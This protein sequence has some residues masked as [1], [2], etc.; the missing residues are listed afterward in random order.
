M[1]GEYIRPSELLKRQRETGQSYW[2]LIG[3][4]LYDEGKDSESIIEDDPQKKADLM[5]AIDYAL[6]LSLDKPEYNEGKDKVTY[7]AQDSGLSYGSY[8]DFPTGDV[9]L[10][11]QKLPEF[12]D[13]KDSKKSRFQEAVSGPNKKEVD[14]TIDQLIGYGMSPIHVAGIVGNFAQESLFDPNAKGVGGFTGI[15]QMSPDMVKEVKRAYGKVNTKTINS[16]IYDSMSQNE[17]ISKEWRA[18]MKQN[19]GYYNNTYKTPGDAAVAFGKVFERPNEKYANWDQRSLS[20]QHAHDYIMKRYPKFQKKGKVVKKFN[21]GDDVIYDNPNVPINIQY[22]PKDSIV[23]NPETGGV[24]TDNGVEGGIMLPEVS[25]VSNK[26]TAAQRLGSYMKK[27]PAA[28]I[29]KVMLGT[30]ALGTLPITAQGLSSLAPGSAFWTN[31]ITQETFKSTIGALGVDAITKEISGITPEEYVENLGVP[32]LIS[33][34]FNPGGYATPGA[35]KTI[36]NI[37]DVVKNNVSNKVF[38]TAYNHNLIKDPLGEPNVPKDYFTLQSK[39]QPVL[40]KYGPPDYSYVSTN[41]ELPQYGSFNSSQQNLQSRI[42]PL[43]DEDGNVNMR[44]LAQEVQKFYKSHPEARNYKTVYNDSG[45]LYQHIRDVVKTAQDS[46]IP[47]GYTRQQYIQ[48]ALFHDIGK[49]LNGSRKYHGL[50]SVDM[51]KEAGIDIDSSVKHAI[52]SHM[53][54]NMLDQDPLT[55]A[56]RF[57]DVGRG[58][59][60]DKTAYDFPYLAYPGM[61][62]RLDEPPLI[63]L[64]EELKTRINPWLMSKGYKTI[65]LNSSMEEAEKLVNQALDQHLS[66]LR[67]VRLPKNPRNYSD[68]VNAAK[69]EFNTDTPSDKQI[70]S[71]TATHVPDEQSGSGRVGLFESPNN[72]VYLGADP[73]TKDGLYLS[74]SN[75]VARTYATSH[76]N[77]AGAQVVIKLRRD[78]M[79]PGESLSEYILRSD[80]SMYDNNTLRLGDRQLYDDPYR[81]QTGRSL[82]QDMIKEDPNFPRGTLSRTRHTTH[83]TEPVDEKMRF[84]DGRFVRVARDGENTYGTLLNQVNKSLD[85]LGISKKIE[86]NEDGIIFNPEGLERLDFILKDLCDLKNGKT[87][88][89]PPYF[90][91]IFSKKQIKN[92]IRNPH[93]KDKDKY[94]HL[95][96][97]AQKSLSEYFSGIKKR[98]LTEEAK[99]II[100]EQTKYLQDPQ[101]KVRFMRSK[102]IKPKYEIEGF[103]DVRLFG[104]QTPRYDK[105]KNFHQS[106]FVGFVIGNKG[107]KVADV[108]SM[109]DVNPL[110]RKYRDSATEAKDGLSRKSMGQ[111]LLKKPK[112]RK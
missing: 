88:N 44:K 21:N 4:P 75:S 6:S 1:K 89:I 100:A 83:I 58:R 81:L 110:K 45:N 54:D 31:P 104:Q 70:L 98:H 25:V 47:K 69:K 91:N 82:Q 8:Y 112:K 94:L 76:D 24:V 3:R 80:P 79:R 7:V 2:D 86:P 65:P 64:R 14:A 43:V 37:A 96:K 106:P 56:L 92:V 66:M 68:A 52:E 90:E 36:A 5:A 27:A 102:G 23:V 61:F 29:D 15:A 63:P 41:T 55:R 85:Q 22:V 39:E 30:L 20:S 62:G 67:G 53:K 103:N 50:T 51:L 60:Y 95:Y 12:Q 108:V 78:K 10:D 34:I 97:V 72:S 93:V 33:P 111:K 87:I 42:N 57:A 38:R 84:V 74:T 17:K 18:Y 28:D 105:T 48:A 77:R 107:E 73:H 35:V 13:G 11:A 26:P 46:P 71:V 101:N 40:Y 19:G 16:F 59:S 109:E 9:T 32:S 99:K 49:V